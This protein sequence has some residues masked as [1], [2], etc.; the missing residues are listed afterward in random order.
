MGGRFGAVAGVRTGPG[1]TN[2]GI[3]RTLV[4]G[5]PV[6]IVCQTK[7]EPASGLDDSLSN[8]W[9]KLSKVT[10]LRTST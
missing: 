4:D 9:D 6:D 2:Y 1:Y 5:D 10:M 3:T 7:G 8:V